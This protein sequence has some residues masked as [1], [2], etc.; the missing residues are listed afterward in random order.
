MKIVY[1]GTPDFAVPALLKIYGEGHDIAACVCQP[2]RP[3][4]RSGE[5]VPPPV[6]EAALKLGIPV[7]QPERT[8][9]PA[10]MEEMKRICPDVIVV[11]AYGHILRKELLELPRFGCI[12][13]HA[14][15]L[16]KYRGAA[17][18]QCAVL[19]G[20]KESGVTVMQMAEGMDTGDILLQEAVPLAADETGDSLFEKLSGLGA[21][22]IVKALSL[23]EKGEL[24]AVPQDE[25]L[26]TKAPMLKKELG[27][28]DF[29]LTAHA[30]DC[31]IR[32][33]TSWPG[34]Y[35]FLNGKMLKIKKAVPA[36]NRYPDACPGE[37]RAENGHLFLR[38][39]DGCLE[40]TE[41]Q[42][43]GKK[44]MP[45][46]DFLRGQGALFHSGGPVKLQNSKGPAERR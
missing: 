32:G 22:L 45:A 3:K 11:A 33:V 12:N 35:S 46:D 1:M 31:L 34:A 41:V 15:L 42:L 13:I 39:S 17:P 8:T 29:G 25:A 16:P 27:N 38:F 26:A 10:F 36:G 28:L 6:K 20:E 7:F 18:I 5:P 40:L 14:S 44:A 43:E 4:G 37:L 21:G 19:N 9:D 23:L 2:D 30:A 24:K